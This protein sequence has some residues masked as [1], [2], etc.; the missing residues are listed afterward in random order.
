MLDR[1]RR[2]DQHF[3]KPVS[4]LIGLQFFAAQT[5]SGR[6]KFNTRLTGPRVTEEV[7]A[8]AHF[9]KPGKSTTA[10]PIARLAATSR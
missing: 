3:N 4:N 1:I 8:F 2:L 6:I 7:V 10:S 5:L 9:G